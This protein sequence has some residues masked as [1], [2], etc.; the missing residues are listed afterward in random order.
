MISQFKTSLFNSTTNSYSSHSIPEERSIIAT[1]ALRQSL[2]LSVLLRQLARSSM[3]SRVL[4]TQVQRHEATEHKTHRLES[5]QNSMSRRESRRIS[6]AVDV[7]GD[8]TTN[9]AEG[10]VHCH[11]DTAFGRA[12]DVVA[13]PGDALG[14]VGVD[15]AGDEEDADVF[16]GVVL[17]GD[18]HDEAD[19]SGVC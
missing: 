2:G 4:A 8:H 13:V 3:A 6:G 1:L 19:E 14:D 7:G 9:V 11:A 16:D 5:N 18:E 15:A 17:G 12:A 10:Y